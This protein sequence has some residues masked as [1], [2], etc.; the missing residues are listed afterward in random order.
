MA[1]KKHIKKTSY[2]CNTCYEIRVFKTTKSN[3]GNSIKTM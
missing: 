3:R 1:C 2:G